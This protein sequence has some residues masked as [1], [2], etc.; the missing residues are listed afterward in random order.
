MIIEKILNNNVVVTLDPTT[1]KE[2]ILMGC[3]IAFKK[4]AGEEVDETRIEKRFIVDN[5]DIGNK[6]KKLMSE[7]PMEIIEI[8]DDIV[9]YAEKML[10]KKLDKHI[11]V[12]LADHIAFA[13]RRLSQNIVIKNNLLIEIKRIHREEFEIGKWALD[14]I[15]SEFKVELPIDEA[16]F[17]AFHI[18][19]ASYNDT[20]EESVLMTNVVKGVLNII[21]YHYSVEFND[22]EDDINYERLLT[23][24]KFFAKRVVSGNQHVADDNNFIDL[25]KEK[26]EEAFK[27]ALKV[28]GFIKTKYKYEVTDDELVY[29]SLHIHRV[30][31][32]IKSK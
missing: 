8:T 16:G 20:M 31:S 32:V 26:Y 24:L 30:I 3:G 1:N 15:N 21:R 25:I 7:I 14:F 23:H 18:I 9:N 11:Y 19:N 5:E 12:S 22:E 13:L 4:K 6:F 28:K 17:I 29:L 10:N 27:C 2:T